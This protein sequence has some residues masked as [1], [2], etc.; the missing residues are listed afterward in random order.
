MKNQINRRDLIRKAE[1]TALGMTFLSA[2]AKKRGSIYLC[3]L[4]KFSINEKY[5]HRSN[6]PFML[7][8]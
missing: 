8:Y 6:H 5:F 7:L 4:S 1:P 2:F 3:I